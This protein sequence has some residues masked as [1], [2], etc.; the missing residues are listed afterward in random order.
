MIEHE[1]IFYQLIIILYDVFSQEMF[2]TIFVADTFRNVS[3]STNTVH[4]LFIKRLQSHQS[5]RLSATTS[6]HSPGYSIFRYEKNAC[7]QM[8][9]VS[10]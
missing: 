4:L 8:A 10:K 1:L 6:P 9:N 5:G 3:V 2:Q 7:F